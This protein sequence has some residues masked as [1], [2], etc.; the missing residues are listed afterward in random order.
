MKKIVCLILAM[1]GALFASSA[2]AAS[3]CKRPQALNTSRTIAVD[4]AD[5]PL[6]GRQQ[7]AETLRL[8]DGEVVLTFDDGPALSS[9]KLVLDALAAECV[10]AT[11]FMLGRNAVEA[12]D[13]VRRA[14]DEGHSIGT[15]TFTHS[16]LANV[17]LGEAKRDIDLGIEALTEALGNK[18]HVMPFFRAPFLK[19]TTQVEKYAL[20]RGLM[21]WSIDADSSDW[22][23]TTPEEVVRRSVAQLESANKGILL[24]HDI[25]AVTARALPLLLRE[26]KSR[27]FRVVH[28]VAKPSLGAGFAPARGERVSST[29]GSA[30]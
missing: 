18:R 24:L 10:K 3:E 27:N 5:F 23:L 19:I 1:M 2:F 22:A 6:I 7:Y 29:D 8:D 4:P 30:N 11:F 21:I 28:V 20:S 15:H 14:Y 26:L 17:P 12:T 9:T 16:N 13:L 25:K